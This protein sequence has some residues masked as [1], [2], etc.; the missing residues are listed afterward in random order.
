MN[1]PA[2][3]DAIKKHLSV[4]IPNLSPPNV[5]I[6][7]PAGVSSGS[8]SVKLNRVTATKRTK[9]SSLCLATLKFPR[10]AQTFRWPV[11]SKTVIC[12]RQERQ[13]TGQARHH[14]RRR[15]I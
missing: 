4:F 1:L 6:G 14:E 12:S 13:V 3:A 9:I 8:P 10:L 7:G 5:F 11:L 2:E 15:G